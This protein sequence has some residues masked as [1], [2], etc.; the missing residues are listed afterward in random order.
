MPEDTQHLLEVGLRACDVEELA[1]LGVGPAEGLASSIHPTQTFAV[2]ADGEPV[3]LFGVGPTTD[4]E[5]GAPWFLATDGIYRVANQ[6]A[7]QTV[8]WVTWMNRVYPRLRNYM[9]DDNRVSMAWLRRAGF[10]IHRPQPIGA[11]GKLYRLFTRNR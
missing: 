3:A 5:V 7:E 6:F 4:P 1:G 8:Y 2:T 11:G 10:R 9:A